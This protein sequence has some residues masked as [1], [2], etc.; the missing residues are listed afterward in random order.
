MFPYQ[1]L[2]A[3]DWTWMGGRMLQQ[4]VKHKM[5]DDAVIEMRPF[6]DRAASFFFFCNIILCSGICFTFICNNAGVC[7]DRDFRE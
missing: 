2:N 6:I 7:D 4:L 3:G 1:Y 5:I